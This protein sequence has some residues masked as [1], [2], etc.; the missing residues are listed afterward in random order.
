MADSQRQCLTFS[1]EQAAD[2]YL[3][4]D[5]NHQLMHGTTALLKVADLTLEGRHNCANVLAALALGHAV[6]LSDASMCQAI[7]HFVGLPHRMQKVAEVNGIS[8]INDSKAT[9]IGACI[10]ALQG[11]AQ[12]VVLIA[13][14]DGKGADMAELQP[15]VASKT[16]AVVVM[17]KDAD[18]IAQAV[19]G[20]V[21]VVHADGMKSAVVQAAQLASTG[22]TVL[23]SP[24]CASLDQYQSYADRGNQFAQAVLEL[25]TC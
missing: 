16:K 25:G 10:A 3:S 15:V 2:F 11:Y 8:W 5:G 14:G 19:A 24:A 22:D 6:G 18:L 13:G 9:N 17:G 12:P 20:V 23:L 7:R 4:N 21:P 1:I